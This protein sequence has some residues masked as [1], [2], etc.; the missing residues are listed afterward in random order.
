MAIVDEVERIKRNIANIYAEA[1]NK[2]AVITGERNSDNLANVVNTIPTGGSTVEKGI[3]L[4]EFDSNGYVTKAKVVGLTTIPFYYLYYA[5]YV[6]GS[7]KSWLANATKLTLPEGLTSIGNYAFRYCTNLP[8]VSL[9]STLTSIG[10][11]AFESCTNLAL[12]SLPDSLTT[13]NGYTF[14]NCKN[15]ALT[16]LPSNLSVVGSFAFKYCSKLA[17][18]ELPSSI[19]SIAQDSFN[20]CTSLEEVKCLATTITIGSSAFGYCSKLAKFILPNV[21]GVATLSNSNAFNGT[22]IKS[23]TGYI[24]VPD[25]LVENY[26][27]A[28]NWSTYASQIKGL[29]ELEG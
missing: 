29:S 3:V 21:T 10:S 26:K 12:T 7:D 19:K 6:N 14:Q 17:I 1:E 23:G 11:Y 27:T 25:D 24:Y 4:E 5:G 9:P 15:L 13:I 20:S 16:S 8:L 22:P 18:K 2:G 28:S